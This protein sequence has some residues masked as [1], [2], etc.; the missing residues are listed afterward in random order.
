[1]IESSVIDALIKVLIAFL[2]GAVLGIEREM[3][4]HPA[5]LRTHVLVTVGSTAFTL[6][7]FEIYHQL[8]GTTMVDPGRVIQGVITGIGFLGGG[9]ILKDRGHVKGLTTAAAIWIAS[10]V[11]V[12]IGTNMFILA[13]TITVLAIIILSVMHK[14]ELSVKKK[15]RTYKLYVRGHDHH[16]I[17]TIVPKMMEKRGALVKSKGFRKKGMDIL[18]NYLVTLPPKTDCKD[19]LNSVIE[20]ENVTEAYWEN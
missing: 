12:L 13:V 16:H 17:H 2:L 15:S 3:R 19:I 8:V 1:M 7:G 18:A 11:G 6:V 10:A 9:A 5:G 4:K 14:L 20:M